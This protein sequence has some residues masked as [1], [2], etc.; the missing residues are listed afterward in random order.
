MGGFIELAEIECSVGI[1][2]VSQ[3]G[4]S[5]QTG[6]DLLEE[7]ELFTSRVGCLA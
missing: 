2:N 6:D 3:S 4:Q 7:F 1:I 5:I